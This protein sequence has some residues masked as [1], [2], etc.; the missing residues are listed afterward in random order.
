M[1]FALPYIPAVL[2]RRYK[3]FLADVELANGKTVTVH[4][5][6]TGSMLGVAEPGMRIWLRDAGTAG[7]RKYRYSWEMSEPKPGVFVGVH[8]GLV[9]ALVS[10]AIENGTIDELQGYPS[11]EQE[12]RYGHENS[13][14]D[15][16]L[17]D[18][19]RRCYV[20]IKN[21]TARDENG[22]AIFPDAVSVRG[23]KHLREL[24]RVVDNG[25]RAVMFYCIQRADITAFRPADEIDADYA[26]LLRAA[27]EAGVEVLAYRADVHPTGVS[28]TRPV[29]LRI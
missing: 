15:L 21:V 27:V 4:T 17:S 24:M 23:Q 1:K 26:R 19:E 3:R 6:N 10:E 7:G 22:L 8:T 20:E 28:L 2:L 25:Q 11:L 14:I 9:N 13:R 18:A 5:P 29:T 16:L 12:V